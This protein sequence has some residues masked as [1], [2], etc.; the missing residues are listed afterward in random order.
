MLT[1]SCSGTLSGGTSSQQSVQLGS[2]E[3]APAKLY[4]LGKP[5]CSY[6]LLRNFGLTS[7]RCLQTMARMAFAGHS[8]LVTSSP[9]RR[10]YR[11]SRMASRYFRL[12]AN[13]ARALLA[14]V[15]SLAAGVCLFG[16]ERWPQDVPTHRLTDDESIKEAS[17]NKTASFRMDDH[18]HRLAFP[19]VPGVL[20]SEL[21]DAAIASK[22]GTTET[23]KKQGSVTQGNVLRALP[24]IDVDP[25]T[26]QVPPSA[27]SELGGFCP[28]CETCGLIDRCATCRAGGGSS[29]DSTL[30]GT[31][32][33]AQCK[34][35][36]FQNTLVF[37]AG[38]G[39][40]NIF[41]DDDNNN[42]GFRTGFNSG[43]D[44]L[45]W[46]GVRGQ[47]GMSYGAYD[48]HG[49]EQPFQTI[50][51][52]LRLSRDDPVEQ[53][54]FATAGVFKRSMISCGDRV[55][56]GGVYDLMT[57]RSMGE[58]S[59]SLLLSQVRGYAG[60][61]LNQRNEIGTWMAFRL[62]DDFAVRQRASVNVTDQ[63]NLFW[64][65][66][67]QQ[68]GDT[69]AYVGWADEPGDVVVGLNGRV[70]LNNHVALF[71]NVHYI[72]PSTTG[73]DVH[74]TLTTVD[75][76]FTQ[77]AWNVSF[78]I[79]FYRGCKAISPDVSGFR[80]LPLLPVADNGTFSFQTQL[81]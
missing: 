38:D 45:G 61:A 80:S 73:G 53:Q 2:L 51:P 9:P 18:G 74:P 40:K 39:W 5:Y 11:G 64:H 14:I 78:G 30:G 8:F 25:D 46:R 65:H 28:E 17:V 29:C 12:T 81:P 56:W 33:V 13:Q 72:I 4:G 42:F 15:L 79:V 75:D 57:G 32:A 69:M 63:A 36:F 16:A 1:R 76:V 50:L 27:R 55:A 35:G 66:T 67:W 7:C 34:E 44:L 58:L 21:T 70:P 60:F 37:L 47:F 43:I 62:M 68:G 49:R 77:E 48:F 20:L 54:V 31:S 3:D 10:D 59:D 71:G 19:R 41:D 52:D 6:R 23:S 22:P 24:P 26:I